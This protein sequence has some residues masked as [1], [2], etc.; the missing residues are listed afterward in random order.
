MDQFPAERLTRFLDALN[1]T[2]A[3]TPVAAFGTPP[4]TVGDLRDVESLR[5]AAVHGDFLIRLLNR[6]MMPDRV[7]SVPATVQVLT[8]AQAHAE[9]PELFEGDSDEEGP[10]FNELG[11]HGNAHWADY[12]PDLVVVVR[13]AA[14]KVLMAS[15]ASDWHLTACGYVTPE[16]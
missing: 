10:Y 7:G 1:A 12:A 6:A 9:V 4:L 8:G 3:E 2:P 5:V 14:G 11:A 13:N 16:D 15:N